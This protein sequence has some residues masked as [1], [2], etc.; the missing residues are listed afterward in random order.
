ML[1]TT[2]KSM[3]LNN[4]KHRNGQTTSFELFKDLQFFLHTTYVQIP[5][6]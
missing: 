4:R 3:K 1:V 5:T 2:T 6:G